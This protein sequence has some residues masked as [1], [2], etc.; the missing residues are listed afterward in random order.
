MEGILHQKEHIL[1]L[2]ENESNK[3]LNNPLLS[4]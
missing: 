3:D 4:L 1:D 2:L